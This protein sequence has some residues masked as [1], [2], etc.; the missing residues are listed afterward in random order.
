LDNQRFI[1][2]S[3]D[4]KCCQRGVAWTAVALTAWDGL[5]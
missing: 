5:L 3:N 2:S 4:L 1:A